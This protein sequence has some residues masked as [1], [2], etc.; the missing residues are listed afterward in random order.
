M[1]GAT[2]GHPRTFNKRDYIVFNVCVFQRSEIAVQMIKGDIDQ[3]RHALRVNVIAGFRPFKSLLL[4][5][6]RALR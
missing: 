6:G 1:P 3:L 2:R 4:K 5:A